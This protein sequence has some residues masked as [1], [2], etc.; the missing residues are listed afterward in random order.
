MIRDIFLFS[1]MISALTLLLYNFFTNFSAVINYD[2]YSS[3]GDL[4]NMNVRLGKAYND[5]YEYTDF[6]YSTIGNVST[7]PE[8]TEGIDVISK[9]GRFATVVVKTFVSVFFIPIEIV[10]AIA[11]SLK[12]DASYS[13]ISSY[14]LTAVFVLVVLEVLSIAT[15]YP[16]DR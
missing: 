7:S 15:R 16:L 5:V 6:A 2:F 10:S 12:I 13:L 14:I 1:I 4:E 3:S 11:S 8:Q 9:L